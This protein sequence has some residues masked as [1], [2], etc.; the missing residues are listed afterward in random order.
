M[1]AA[2]VRSSARMR[3]E[4]RTV[5][6][7]T[8]FWSLEDFDNSTNQGM[9]ITDSE[10]VHLRLGGEVKDVALSDMSGVPGDVAAIVKTV[11]KM[12]RFTP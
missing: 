2:T 3:E 8:V 11:V 4:G 6:S 1:S 9:L 10:H 5:I 12:D 7:F